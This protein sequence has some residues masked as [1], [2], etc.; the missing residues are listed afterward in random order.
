MVDLFHRSK[1]T[2]IHYITKT[3]NNIG[4]TSL[5]TPEKD[6]ALRRKNVVREIKKNSALLVPKLTDT[7]KNTFEKKSI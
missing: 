3:W 2:E 1:S 7:I 6:N 4:I 5:L